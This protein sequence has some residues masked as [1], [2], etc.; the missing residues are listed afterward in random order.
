MNAGQICMSTERVLVKASHYESLTRAL[1]TA[2]NATEKARTRVLFNKLGTSR[3]RALIDDAVAKGATHLLEPSYKHDTH[4]H[5]IVPTIL[6]PVTSEMRLF[7]EETFAPVVIVVVVPDQGRVEDDIIDEM[8]A[9]ANDSE[10]GLTAS[11]WG[12]DTA[13]ATTVA[14][15]LEVGAVHINKPVHYVRLYSSLIRAG[16]GPRMLMGCTDKPRPAKRASW[17]MEV[18]GMGALQRGRGDTVVHP[19]SC[20]LSFCV[21]MSWIDALID[22]LDRNTGL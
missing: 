17:R 16:I 13:R 1:Q 21:T 4:E 6:G 20:H 9:L 15:R 22:S 14:R 11:V 7:T 2:W 8:I 5:R 19:G 3:V 10:Y 18:F 12:R